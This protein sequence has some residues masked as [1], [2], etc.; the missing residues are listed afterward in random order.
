MVKMDQVHIP[1]FSRHG[2]VQLAHFE[3][4]MG[5]VVMALAKKSRWEHAVEL[6]RRRCPEGLTAT[7]AWKCSFFFFEGHHPLWPNS[8]GE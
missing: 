8:S 3:E 2:R 5:D 7:E 1:P 4:D 6:A